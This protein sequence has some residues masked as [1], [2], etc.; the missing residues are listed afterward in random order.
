[1]NKTEFRSSGLKIAKAYVALLSLTLSLLS[2]MASATS[3]QATTVTGITTKSGLVTAITNAVAGDT[4]VLGSDIIV[5]SSAISINKNI[6]IDGN[7]YTVTVPNVGVL[8]DGTNSTAASTWG[9]FSFTAAAS[10]ATLSNMSIK[11]GNATSGSL[12]AVSVPSGATVTLQNCTISN[13]RNSASGGGGLYNLGT[14]YLTDS[15]VIRNS[16]SYGGGFLNRGT[17]YVDR[18]TFAENRSESAGGGGGAGENGSGAYMYVN[19]STF[20]NNVS[21]EI[22]GAIN[23]YNGNIYAVNSTFTG[24]V[25]LSNS[26]YGGAIGKNGGTVK[27]ASSLFAYNYS[28]TG[29]T[30]AAPTAFQLDDID[31]G[32]ITLA[33]SVYHGVVYSSGSTLV[34]NTQY[35]AAADGSNDTMFSGGTNAKVTNGAGAQVGTANVFRPALTTVNGRKV[36]AITSSSLAVGAGTPTYFGKAPGRASYYDRLAATPA[37]V[38]MF[39]TATSADLVSADQVSGVRSASTPT[40]GAVENG[41]SSLYV[42]KSVASA[43]GTVDGGASIYGN[44]YSSGASV[45][46]TAL[47]NAGKVFSKWQVVI[48]TGTS[49][50]VTSNP[51]TFA[52][53]ANTTLTP[54]FVAAAVNTYTVSY[55]ANNATVGSPPASQTF[56]A[57]GSALVASTNSGSLSR[58]GYSFG[59]WSTTASG[60]GTIYAAGSGTFTPSANMNLYAYWVP[61]TV[62]NIS[63]GSA[64]YSLTTGTSATITPTNTGGSATSWSISPSAPAGMNFGSTTG[65]LT[66][67][68]S[69]AQSSTS[70]TITATNVA[71]SATANFTITITAPVVPFNVVA[72]D[73][74]FAFGGTPPSL[75]HQANPTQLATAPTCSAYA[76]SDNA[77]ATPLTLSSST[78]SGTYVIHCVGGSANA[79]YSIAGYTD[80][81]L[82]VSAPA[83][84]V[85]TYNYDLATGGN[86]VSS[87]TFT[88]GGS[89]LL[90]PSTTRTNFEF[91]G[92]YSASTG[93]TRLGLAGASFTPSASVTLY[94]RWVQVSLAG[95]AAG[96][97]VNVGVLLASDLIDTTFGATTNGSSVNVS[98]PAGAFVNGTQVTINLLTNFTQAQNI[99]TDPHNYVLSLV[100]S[101]LAPDGTVPT[102]AAGKPVSMTISNA[103]IKRGDAIYV[104]MRGTATLVGRATVNGQAVVSITDDPQIVIAS[105]RPNAVTTVTATDGDNASSTISWTAP[106]IDGGSAITGYTV[107][108]AGGLS[109]TT[110]TTSC[111]ISGLTNGTA[112][113][114]TVVATN[115]IGQSTTATSGAITPVAAVNNI[116]VV[117]P[118]VTQPVTPPVTSPPVTLPVVT[119]PVTAP[120]EPPV[121]APVPPVV[122]PV[123]PVVKTARPAAK[124]IATFTSSAVGQK[125]TGAQI[126]SLKALKAT[127]G[128][129]VTVFT[130]ALLDSGSRKAMNGIASRVSSA[131]KSAFKKSKLKVAVAGLSKTPCK[132]PSGVC[133]A[134]TATK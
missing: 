67:A 86:S 78:A 63:V 55:S 32:P 96:D 80:A 42:V 1:M 88:V 45:T 17:M 111:Q 118:P 3:A 5:D 13:S 122:T 26:T 125:L 98:V 77:F 56:T 33:Y 51:Y 54:V 38:S 95:L 37:W 49:V 134:I 46:V 47:P 133:I 28:R 103:S 117:T 131:V 102:T 25:T 100:V 69:S 123:T 4:L 126:A 108:T 130:R 40:A 43:E 48:G 109:C 27:V 115:A 21:S 91:E 2:P 97:L 84:Y 124:K 75:T 52:V 68:P 119:P 110:S 89:A 31:Y 101:W 44:T 6:T 58:S 113:T 72:V 8:D 16:A 93:G 83:S 112:Y 22:G 61:P 114:F 65:V 82:T 18:S 76:S 90:L 7:G 106:S 66:G 35:T 9:V 11:G 39:G 12:G 104:L 14:V 79:G 10:A 121:V 19:N 74:T 99:L 85:V 105:T 107:T 20:A 94:A 59:G 73:A 57:G 29:G 92:W 30:S 60:S 53:S 132:S 41:G 87:A 128:F 23:N 62:P 70:Y 81:T 24:N 64:S 120:V 129:T 50:D 36:V 71:G 116:Q 34:R 15:N 127:K